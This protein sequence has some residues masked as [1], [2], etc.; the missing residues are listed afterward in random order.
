VQTPFLSLSLSAHSPHFGQGEKKNLP[1]LPHFHRLAAVG[2]G[3]SGGTSVASEGKGRRRPSLDIEEVP[4]KALS[5]P[6]PLPFP[7]AVA[8]IRS[9]ARSRPLVANARRRRSRASTTTLSP[10]SIDA[11]SITARLSLS[12]FVVVVVVAAS[13]Q[14][15]EN[16]F[17]P[18]VTVRRFFPYLTYYTPPKKGCE[19]P[20]VSPRIDGCDRNPRPDKERGKKVPLDDNNKLRLVGER[21]HCVHPREVAL[22]QNAGSLS[23]AFGCVFS[24]NVSR[25][26]LSL[27]SLATSTRTRAK[28]PLRGRAGGGIYNGVL[29]SLWHSKATL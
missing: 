8:L 2:R 21:G 13:R 7:L 1:I 29:S 19:R 17:L 18:L 22:L 15:G 23:L 4:G 28:V 3:W 25:R 11:A 27:L 9:L 16:D 24:I 12:G 5:P 10:A 20:F 26:L 6:S 14:R